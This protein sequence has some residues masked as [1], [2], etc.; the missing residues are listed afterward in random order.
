MNSPGVGINLGIVRD[1]RRDTN[2]ALVRRKSDHPARLPNNRSQRNILQIK[3][4]V[5]GLYLGEV[6]DF[7]DQSEEMLTAFKD[8][9]DKSLFARV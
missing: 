7:I 9:T 1:F 4:A 5:P 3:F 2:T 8:L 6:E